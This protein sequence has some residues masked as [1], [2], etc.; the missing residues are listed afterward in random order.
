M[1]SIQ[2]CTSNNNSNIHIEFGNDVDFPITLGKL[3]TSH[4]LPPINKQTSLLT[5]YYFYKSSQ[6]FNINSTHFKVLS[7]DVVILSPHTSY[8]TGHCSIEPL[9]LY[10]IQFDPSKFI[11]VN[12]A[13]GNKECSYIIDELLRNSNAPFKV[14]NN[15]KHCIENLLTTANEA[16]PLKNTMFR[17]RLL[18]VLTELI[19]YA[20]LPVQ[21]NDNF[22][23]ESV[24]YITS[25]ICEPINIE[26]LANN[27]HLSVSQFKVK[28]RNEL[29]LP[30]NEYILREK[31]NYAKILLTQTELS[32]TEIAYMLSFSSSQYFS[33]VFKRLTGIT[34]S[35]LRK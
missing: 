6:S 29:R 11:D 30:P 4:A 25:H 28:F 1:H 19:K 7:N 21:P 2:N 17:N 24:D 8:N 18:T 3:T 33:T 16:S 27:A 12:F 32:I 35:D 23:N 26:V 20:N 5:I 22:L 14:K 15:I 34:P 10:Y 13:F 9:K 31:V